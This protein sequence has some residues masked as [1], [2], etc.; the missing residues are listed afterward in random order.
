MAERVRSGMRTSLFALTSALAIISMPWATQASPEGWVTDYEKAKLDAAAAKK[1]LLLDFTGSDWCGWCIRL[2]K[3][4]FDVQAFKDAAPK[5]FVLVELDFPQNASLVSPEVRKQ[6]EAL[7]AQFAVKGYPSIFLTDASG[8]PYAQTGYQKGGAEAYLKHL[9]ELREVRVKRDAAF[10]R[11]EGVQGMEKAKALKEGLDVLGEEV[12]AAH[13]KGVLGQIRELD[14]KDE[15]GL[16]AKF[17]FLAAM[18][19]LEGV[20]G[21]KKSAGAEAL[22]A[23]VEEFLKKYPNATKQQKQEALFGVLNYLV[24]PKDNQAA[25][26]LLSDIRA[27]DPE[28]EA[29]KRA[30]E[31]HERVLKMIEKQKGK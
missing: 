29:G 6:N 15:L 14:P 5:D 22:R 16:D 8:R 28:S 27:L 1:D 31:I 11:A 9:A 12:V 25:A 17:G 24:P 21:S 19:E 23:A 30:G 18:S 13:Y 10:A 3:E 7:Q 4:V 20:L 26:T 2:R